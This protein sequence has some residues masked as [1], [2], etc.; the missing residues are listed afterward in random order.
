M[1][2]DLVDT[3]VLIKQKDIPKQLK[4]YQ[5][6]TLPE[7]VTS[8]SVIFIYGNKVALIIW[9][10]EIIINV[11][12]SKEIVNHYKKYF[13]Y[14][15][16]QDVRVSHGI[17]AL[18]Q[19]HEKTYQQLKKGEEY[20]ALGIPKYQPAEHHAYWQKDH[21]RRIKAGIKCRLLFNKDT[22]KKIIDNRNSYRGCDT[23]YMP[24]DI[25]TPSYMMIY[26][27]TIMMAIPKKEPVVIEINNPEI[28]DSFKAYF[29]EF[30]K[31]SK[32][33]K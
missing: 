17:K 22:D 19:A 27:D 16:E 13:D 31:I 2:L 33:R 18:M 11:I 14:L 4:H 5:V 20:V 23:R 25:K 28:V 10:K 26:K 24:T 7:Q 3:D 15:W 21:K 29:E 12:E 9:E 30:W 1:W 8:P 32:K 6:K